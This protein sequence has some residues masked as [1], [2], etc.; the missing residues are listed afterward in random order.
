MSKRNEYAIAAQAKVPSTD[1]RAIADHLGLA[2]PCGN[3][4]ASRICSFAA[5]A[6]RLKM[7]V[8]DAIAAN[9]Q[10]QQPQNPGQNP[11]GPQVGFNVGQPRDYG[12]NR[13]QQTQQGQAALGGA[14][15]SG[16]AAWTQ[17]RLA[18]VT[19][20]AQMEEWANHYQATGQHHPAIQGQPQVQALIE[21]VLGAEAQMLPQP[22]FFDQGTGGF[23]VPMPDP[24]TLLHGLDTFRRSGVAAL[25]GG[26]AHHQVKA[27]PGG[28]Q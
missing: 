21:Q 24:T 5:E 25:P 17:K 23:S 22:S 27:L 19:A 11:G 4:D 12:A 9:S 28:Q 18:S 13:Q 7:T 2:L 6:K 1:V 16:M 20:E 26:V 14:A 15:M 3:E 8:R 10:P